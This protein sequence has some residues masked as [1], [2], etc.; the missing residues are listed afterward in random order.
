VDVLADHVFSLRLENVNL[1]HHPC[2]KTRFEAKRS[3]EINDW[4][5]RPCDPE[6]AGPVCVWN[7]IREAVE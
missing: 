4:A 1:E 3:C 7:L 5:K 6:E 2:Y